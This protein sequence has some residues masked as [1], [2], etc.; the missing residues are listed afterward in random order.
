MTSVEKCPF[1]KCDKVLIQSRLK[2]GRYL[3]VCPMCDAERQKFLNKVFGPRGEK[4]RLRKVRRFYKGKW[5]PVT[6]EGVKPGDSV[7]LVQD[8]EVVD[9]FVVASYPERCEPHGN[10]RV[11][12][13]SGSWHELMVPA[14]LVVD[15]QRYLQSDKWTETD[16]T[17]RAELPDGGFAPVDLVLLDRDSLERWLAMQGSSCPTINNLVMRLLGHWSDTPRGKS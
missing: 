12:D 2:P 15:D 17:V 11:K 6:F 9:E 1:H 13:D 5:D 3:R 4:V 16:I 8:N 14:E 7:R 10:M